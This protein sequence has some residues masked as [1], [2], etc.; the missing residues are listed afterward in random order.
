MPEIC[1]ERR[2]KPVFRIDTGTFSCYHDKAL[3]KYQTNL[4]A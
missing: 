2:E 3:Y 1:R 4:T